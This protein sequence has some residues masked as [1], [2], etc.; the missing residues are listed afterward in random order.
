[1]RANGTLT[2]AVVQGDTVIASVDRRIDDTLAAG[3]RVAYPRVEPVLVDA[4]DGQAVQC[5]VR[6]DAA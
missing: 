4:A 1:M 6:F 3:Q 2:T 5:S